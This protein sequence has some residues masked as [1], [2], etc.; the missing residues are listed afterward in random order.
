MPAEEGGDHFR[1]SAA[2]LTA[3]RA[4]MTEGADIYLGTSI[5]QVYAQKFGQDTP[6]PS[7]QPCIESD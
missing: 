5:D 4:R 7:I 2:F 1:S 3:A 6:L